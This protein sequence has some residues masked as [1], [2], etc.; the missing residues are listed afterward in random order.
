MQEIFKIWVDRLREGNIQK[1]DGSFAPLFLEIDEKELQFRVPIQ[2]SG[3]AYVAETHLVIQLNAK[4]KVTV[5]CAICNEM[6]DV[7]LKVD[8]FYHSSGDRRD[9]GCGFRF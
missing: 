9:P 6:M 3:K 4:T 5:P 1:I 7:D 2:V 8:N